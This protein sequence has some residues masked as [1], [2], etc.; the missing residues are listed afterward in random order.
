LS[1]CAVLSLLWQSLGL[2]QYPMAEQRSW[3]HQL[4]S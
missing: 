3:Q 1:R 2:S 4:A